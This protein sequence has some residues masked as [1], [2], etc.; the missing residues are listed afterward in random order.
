MRSKLFVNARPMPNNS[1]DP[2]Q[3]GFRT[4]SGMLVHLFSGRLMRAFEGYRLK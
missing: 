4:L 3:H 2:N 1:F